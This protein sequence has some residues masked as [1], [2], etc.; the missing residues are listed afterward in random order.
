MCGLY[1]GYMGLWLMIVVC[2]WDVWVICGLYGVVANDC[3]VC[4]EYSRSGFR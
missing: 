1:V 4:V 3:S 2:V